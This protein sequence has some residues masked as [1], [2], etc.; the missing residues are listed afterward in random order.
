MIEVPILA[1]NGKVLGEKKEDQYVFFS[2]WL[3]SPCD[4]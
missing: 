1:F 3:S 4:S 2:L